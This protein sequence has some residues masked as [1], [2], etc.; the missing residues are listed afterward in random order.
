MSNLISPEENK[1]EQLFILSFQKHLI[2]PIKMD[3]LSTATLT[4]L[5]R[6]M[7]TT[8]IWR[9]DIYS[10]TF[11]LENIAITKIIQARQSVPLYGC[12]YTAFVLPALRKSMHIR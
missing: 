4:C 5:R 2:K 10:P 7:R 12:D 6:T 8:R 11:Q 3:D 1:I 9:E